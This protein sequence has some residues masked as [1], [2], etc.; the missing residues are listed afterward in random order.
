MAASH[1]DLNK[2]KIIH[3]DMD[4]FYASVEM[5][6]KPEY[7]DRPLAVGGE[8]KGRGVLCTSNYI[9]R[10]FGVRS[11]MPSRKAVEL[12]PELVIVPPR[13]DLYKSISKEIREIFSEYTEKIEPLSLDEAYLDVSDCEQSAT[14]IAMEIKQKIFARTKLTASAGVAPNKL[15]A[16]IASDLR[17]P[18]GISVIKPH[19]V[20]TFMKTLPVSK[21]P[22]VGPVSKRKLKDFGIETCEQI[23]KHRKL[24]LYETFGSRFSD[25][26]W[27]RGQGIDKT[28][29]SND[30]KRKSISVESTFSEDL[31]CEQSIERETLKLSKELF[32]RLTATQLAASSLSV[33]IRYK[34]FSVVS[35]GFSMPFPIFTLE[36][37]EKNAKLCLQKINL[38]SPIRLI[39][40]KASNLVE[41][42]LT[43]NLVQGSLF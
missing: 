5:R 26:L 38:E 33:K 23:F 10:K 4:A 7:Q 8:P 6:D 41:K 32:T 9:A 22:G 25:W 39:G 19:Q 36:D 29:V 40:L 18:N 27:E 42:K 21:I 43:G 34:D 30:R 24:S 2:R 11:A 17:K 31:S 37:L 20:T 14:Q 3:I 1:P 12:C 28:E 35:K 15:L 16:K 13:F